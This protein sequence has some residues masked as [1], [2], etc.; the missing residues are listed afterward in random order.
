MLQLQT[1]K[2][3]GKRRNLQKFR[4]L[5]EDSDTRWRSG[6]DEVTR[7]EGAELGHPGNQGRSLEDQL[8]KK[9]TL[10]QLVRT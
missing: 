2:P 5:L 9:H 1:P 4:R 3:T 10:K 6:E 8:I 7:L